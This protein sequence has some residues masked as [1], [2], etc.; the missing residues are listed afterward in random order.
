MTIAKRL[1]NSLRATDIVGRLGGDEFI[2]W[3]DMLPEPIDIEHKINQLLTN[4]K[5]PIIIGK[6][7]LEVGASIGISVLPEH[8][9][10]SRELITAAD[11]AMYQAK[12]DHS[13][14]YCF[15]AGSYG[16]STLATS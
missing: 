11:T 16:V 9:L 3:L 10:N 13:I 5:Q 7:T 12:A 4:I 8:G 14:E 15:Y 1:V 2:V 6:H